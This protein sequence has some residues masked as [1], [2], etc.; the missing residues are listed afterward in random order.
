MRGGDLQADGSEVYH[1]I[2][3]CMSSQEALSDWVWLETELLPILAEFD[4]PDDA[5]EFVSVKINSLLAVIESSSHLP[6][7][8][9]VMGAAEPSRPP[10]S[11]DTKESIPYRAAQD[12]SP[13]NLGF[14]TFRHVAC[15][16][17]RP[18]QSI[19]H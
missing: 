9:N 15:Y 14:W 3:E 18:P 6:A 1:L 19:C 11:G 12:R 4:S 2:S 5:T 8:S 16:R 13:E 17:A 10:R 7:G